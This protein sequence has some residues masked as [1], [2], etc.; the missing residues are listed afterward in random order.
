M[1]RGK[2]SQQNQPQNSTAAADAVILPSAPF[3]FSDIFNNNI[4][5]TTQQQKKHTHTQSS[6]QQAAMYKIII[7]HNT[8]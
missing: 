6:M 4:N 1:R 3:E 8:I 2:S 5:N 7:I